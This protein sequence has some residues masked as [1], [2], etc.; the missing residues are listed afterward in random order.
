M[1][2]SSWQLSGRIV[3][4]NKVELA[5]FCWYENLHH[6]QRHAY[7]LCGLITKRSLEQK[8]HENEQEPS[9]QKNPAFDTQY[10]IVT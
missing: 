1:K 7:L 8:K 9:T 6:N 3:R 2:I 10:M 4:I 5:N